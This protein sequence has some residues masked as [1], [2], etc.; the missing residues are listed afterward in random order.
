LVEGKSGLLLVGQPDRALE[1]RAFAASAD[2]GLRCA[3]DPLWCRRGPITARDRSTARSVGQTKQ[4][5]TV[6]E[7]ILRTEF[8]ID[9][10]M[11]SVVPI[12]PPSP[13]ASQMWLVGTAPTGD[14]AV[15]TD[16]L[17]GWSDRDW[18]FFALRDGLCFFDL[19]ASAFWL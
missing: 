6:N 3:S 7:G 8:L 17:A 1:V 12:L 15:R 18:R 10:A 19:S 5:I 4:E 2:L 9:S 14:F 16:S 11:K 13:V